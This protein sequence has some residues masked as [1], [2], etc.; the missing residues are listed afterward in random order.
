MRDTC[1][2]LSLLLVAPLV[3]CGDAPIQPVPS[4]AFAYTSYDTTGAPVVTGWFTVNVSS[5]GLI[6]G[7][8]HFW[9]LGNPGDVG[10]QIGDGELV[11]GF[12]EGELWLELNPQFRDHNLTLHGTL[13]GDRYAGAWMW[14]TY[15]GVTNHGTFEA[16]RR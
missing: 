6:S 8:W 7:E 10:P 4:G 3:S 2:L 9:G 1:A 11:G 13:E 14:T 12:A 5:S 15:V 16:F